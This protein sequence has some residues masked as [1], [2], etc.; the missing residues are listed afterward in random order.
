MLLKIFS[1]LHTFWV[2]MSGYKCKCDHVLNHTLVLECDSVDQCFFPP[3]TP[4]STSQALNS[5]CG[6]SGVLKEVEIPQCCGQG[7]KVCKSQVKIILKHFST[8]KCSEV[9]KK[10]NKYIWVLLPAAF[11]VQFCGEPLSLCLRCK[12]LFASKTVS[13]LFYNASRSHCFLPLSIWNQMKSPLL[14]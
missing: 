5:W 10:I 14:V 7:W 12:C 6:Q 9:K 8:F 13:A 3:K 2:I 1:D 4:N 11:S